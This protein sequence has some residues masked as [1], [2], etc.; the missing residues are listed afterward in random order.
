MTQAPETYPEWGFPE[1]ADAEHD[2]YD[3][4][5]LAPGEYTA[6][7]LDD[8]ELRGEVAHVA[9]DWVPEGS[10]LPPNVNWVLFPNGDLMRVAI[11]L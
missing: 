1:A 7:F 3:T 10:K 6:R 11:T 5:R 2:A 8:L 9:D 4:P